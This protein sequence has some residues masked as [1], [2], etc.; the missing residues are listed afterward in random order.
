[1]PKTVPLLTSL[2]LFHTDD[3]D[4]E[5]RLKTHLEELRYAESKANKNSEPIYLTWDDR[6]KI[7]RRAE[8]IIAA[9]SKFTAGKHLS[10]TDKL[11]LKPA[12]NGV[13]LK[14]P[15]TEHEVDEIASLLFDEMPWLQSV[16]K[17]LWLDMRHHVS[18]HGA[19]LKL[20]PTLLVGG[21]GLGKTHLVRRVAE[22]SGLPVVHIDGGAGGEGFPVAGLARGWG[23]AECGRP[24]KTMLSNK[25]ANPV[26]VVDEIDKAGT[27]TGTSGHST[28]LHAAM[29]GLLE[30]VSAKDWHCPYFQTGCDMSHINWLMT[31]N[32]IGRV[33]DLLRSRVR[34]IYIEPPNEIQMAAFIK[35][36]AQRRNLPCEYGDEILEMLEKVGRHQRASIR[37]AV[38]M[39]DDLERLE[40]LPVKQ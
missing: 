27:M 29:L 38:K 25:V 35:N 23:S 36:E 4:I 7:S 30:P 15:E 18:R 21:P 2:K 39:M 6:K 34:T 31:A 11:M 17:E 5:R 37:L 8:K 22:L 10:R 19:G 20:R 24:L 28:S 40:S 12:L 3:A 13:H 32:D 33:P 26:V 16:I 14:G 9:R 1:M